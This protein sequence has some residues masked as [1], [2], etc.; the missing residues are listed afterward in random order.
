MAVKNRAKERETVTPEQQ[1]TVPEDRPTSE[2]FR[3]APSRLVRRRAPLALKV[4]S[5]F[6]LQAGEKMMA[7]VKVESRN[8]RSAPVL[9]SCQVLAVLE[10]RD[11]VHG[12]RESVG[13]AGLTC[14][15][16]C[17][18]PVELHG[19]F[20]VKWTDTNALFILQG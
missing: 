14:G 3:T 11:S 7:V 20:Q 4:I 5:R 16:L 9:Y 8:V 10:E 15:V 18:L 19:G 6:L 1:R 2:I 17:F 12:F 13:D